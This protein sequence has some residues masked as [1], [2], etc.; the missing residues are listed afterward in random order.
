VIGGPMT[1]DGK[2]M[3]ARWL[4]G[5]MAAM[6]GLVSGCA[7]PVA[8]EQPASQADPAPATAPVARPEGTI[9]ATPQLP[10]VPAIVTVPPAAPAAPET[11][12]APEGAALPVPE[13]VVAEGVVPE[14]VVIAPPARNPGDGFLSMPDLPR[15][16][17]I[18][19]ITTPAPSGPPAP[20][21]APPRIREPTPREIASN[22]APAFNVDRDY[23]RLVQCYGTANFAE[24]LFRVQA[25]RAGANSAPAN[26][27]AQTGALKEAMQPLVLAA[28]TVHGEPKFRTD[29]GAI[30]D[31][32]QREFAA[33]R[34]PQAVLHRSLTTVNACR[35][36]INRWR[37]AR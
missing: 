33:A 20:P 8:A 27:A 2:M 21:P 13:G 9:A 18:A 23:N 28:S 29:Y 7:T 37:G 26:A 14:V 5:L 15:L 6:A 3:R 36:D 17:D 35:A 10:P 30:G 16:G 31:R 25:R 34:D 11:A 22:I 4:P 32:W 19:P 12:V 1:F 24:A